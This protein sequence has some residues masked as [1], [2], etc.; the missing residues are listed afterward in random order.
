MWVIPAISASAS[1]LGTAV[2]G[3]SAY[4]TSKKSF[5]R[6]QMSEQVAER[7]ALLRQAA[8]RF[9]TAITD[10]PAESAGLMRTTERIGPVV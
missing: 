7:N 1:L 10:M 6:A 2:G 4:W 5:E 3:F 9:I 8:I